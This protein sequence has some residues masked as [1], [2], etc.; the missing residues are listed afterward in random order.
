MV[1]RTAPPEV[2]A[3]A[4][5]AISK[6]FH[7]DVNHGKAEAARIMQIVNTSYGVL[8]DPEKRR[9]HD[10][11][12]REREAEI[13]GMDE[14]RAYSAASDQRLRQ[15]PSHL[16]KF[17]GW[18]L[19]S[20][21]VGL[22]IFT[23]PGTFFGRQSGLPAYD[24]SPVAGEVDRPHQAQPNATS[25]VRPAKSP[26]GASWPTTAAYV[27]EYP[28][29]RAN[30]LSKL[31]ID[32]SSNSTDM[33]VKLVA[34]DTDRSLPVRHAFIPAFQSFTMNKIRA[35]HYDVRYM[36]LSDG[37]LSRSEAFDLV[38]ISE[39]GGVSFSVTKMTLYK[40]ANGNMQTYALDAGEF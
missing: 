29:A 36:D 40:I 33:F 10:L 22:A 9:A 6:R 30:G 12:I 35:G 26:N 39:P 8:S 1:S 5:R 23:D 15:K 4:Y 38:E 2:I 34:V 17:W 37:T 31:T 25:Y 16:A 7:P 32:N 11:W 19:L 3:A 28:I 14:F 21:I 20:A 13:A 18:Y 27:P 24:P